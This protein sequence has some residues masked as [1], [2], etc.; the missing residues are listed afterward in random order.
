MFKLNQLMMST[1]L[2][3]GCLTVSIQTAPSVWHQFQLWRNQG[4]SCDRRTNEGWKTFYGENC[5]E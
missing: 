1:W 3:V 5:P 2:C 4:I